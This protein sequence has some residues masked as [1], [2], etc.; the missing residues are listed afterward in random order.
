ME[1]LPGN[2]E[3]GTVAFAGE[4]NIQLAD[5]VGTL[6]EESVAADTSEAH[7]DLAPGFEPSSDHCKGSGTSES[8]AV[9]EQ[10]RSDRAVV[11]MK[12]WWQ[13]ILMW[14]ASC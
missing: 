12:W 14:R 9:E 10:H 1:A 5:S 8:W 4:G 13:W 7:K 2:Q 3:M 11:E 6:M